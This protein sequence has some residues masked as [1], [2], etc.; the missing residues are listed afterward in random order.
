MVESIVGIGMLFVVKLLTAVPMQGRDFEPNTDHS[1][2][3]EIRRYMTAP[4]IIVPPWPRIHP[5]IASQL[6]FGRS[7]AKS[8]RHER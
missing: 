2:F 3:V 4:F 7:Q 5:G 6:D 1:R 8:V